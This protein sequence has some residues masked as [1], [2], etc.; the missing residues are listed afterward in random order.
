MCLNNDCLHFY[1]SIRRTTNSQKLVFYVVMLYNVSPPQCRL[2]TVKAMTKV[3]QNN[4]VNI[5]NVLDM[6]YQ[7]GNSISSILSVCLEHDSKES[8]AVGCV[9]VAC[10]CSM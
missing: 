5:N 2:Q 3:T 10:V 1:L 8:Q 9:F 7:M 4:T 6:Q